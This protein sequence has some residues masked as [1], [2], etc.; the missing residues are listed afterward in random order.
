MRGRCSG[1]RRFDAVGTL[2]RQKYSRAILVLGEPATGNLHTP[3]KR[4]KGVKFI[5]HNL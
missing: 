4:E 1:A 2:T 3:R 5:R